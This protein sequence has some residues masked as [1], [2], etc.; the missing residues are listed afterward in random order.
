MGGVAGAAHGDDGHPGG[1]GQPGAQDRADVVRRAGW[2]HPGR[3][4]ALDQGKLGDGRVGQG[5]GPGQAATDNGGGQQAA[6]APAASAPTAASDRASAVASRRYGSQRPVAR[7]GSPKGLAVV[8][9]ITAAVAPSIITGSPGAL[10]PVPLIQ[11]QYSAIRSTMP[12]AAST[13]RAA[14]TRR[15]AR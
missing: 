5:P 14:G 11:C 7:S 12:Q 1:E 13:A 6:A 3:R 9:A 8:T 2:P 15:L 10:S 4:P